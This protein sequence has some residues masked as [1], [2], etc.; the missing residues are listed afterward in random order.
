MVIRIKNLRLRTIIGV[1]DWERVCPQEII[2]NV[3]ME[4]DGSTAAVSDKL[5]DAIDYSELKRR[6]IAQA[7][8][9]RFFLLERLADFILKI[10]MED[11]RIT[12]AVVEV[13]KPHALRFADS[14]SVVTSA[15]R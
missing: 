6:M 11:H 3:E 2:V 12:R 9:A 15:K 7:E 5:Q 8:P 13:D 4:F 1:E 10:V 14:V